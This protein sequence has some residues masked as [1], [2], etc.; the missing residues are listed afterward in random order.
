MENPLIIHKKW[1]GN[2]KPKYLDKI[3]RSQALLRSYAELWRE[4]SETI[5]FGS[6]LRNA[7][8]KR[9]APL[10]GDKIVHADMKISEYV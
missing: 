9:L 10:S 3:I 7:E 1:T 2:L 8:G 4:G 5:P 6:T